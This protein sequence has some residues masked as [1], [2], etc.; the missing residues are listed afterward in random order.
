MT[1]AKDELSKIIETDDLN[2]S[3]L[4][5]GRVTYG[6]TEIYLEKF[7]DLHGDPVCAAPAGIRCGL[8]HS[9]GWCEHGWFPE[10]HVLQRHNQN[11]WYR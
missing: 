9:G 1:W 10:G 6:N 11:G 7:I 8:G 5:E 2:I 4:R 3:P